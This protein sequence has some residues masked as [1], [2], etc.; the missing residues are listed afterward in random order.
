M[1]VRVSLSTAEHE[2]GNLCQ[3]YRQWREEKESLNP[4]PRLHSH[5]HLQLHCVGFKES[6]DSQEGGWGGSFG[7]VYFTLSFLVLSCFF[8][9]F[10]VCIGCCVS[11]HMF[12]F[13]ASV[14]ISFVVMTL[15]LIVLLLRR[16]SRRCSRKMNISIQL[17][18]DFHCITLCYVAIRYVSFVCN[19]RAISVSVE[20]QS[21]EWVTRNVLRQGFPV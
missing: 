4:R 16:S 7:Q 13:G 11:F 14:S 5:I 17:R 9:F 8:V 10:H 15:T 2:F 12:C 19:F 21:I 6:N 20:L 3:A 1:F 18:V